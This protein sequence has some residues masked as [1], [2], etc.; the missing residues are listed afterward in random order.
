MENFIK[1]ISFVGVTILLLFVS[2]LSL[3]AQEIKECKA[4]AEGTMQITQ[5]WQK[6]QC[7]YHGIIIT[8]NNQ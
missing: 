2:I 8:N 4:F 5:Q 7:E 3:S 1:I 6:D